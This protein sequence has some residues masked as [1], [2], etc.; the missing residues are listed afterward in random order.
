MK[1][2]K[3]KFKQIIQEECQKLLLEDEAYEKAKKE[4]AAARVARGE[5][6]RAR[7]EREKKA[8]ETRPLEIF[9]DSS[10]HAGRRKFGG[11][12]AVFTWRGTGGEKIAGWYSYLFNKKWTYNPF[13]KT[14]DL[15]LSAISGK[16]WETNENFILP[17]RTKDFSAEGEKE[18]AHM[19]AGMDSSLPSVIFLTGAQAKKYANSGLI[20]SYTK[21]QN[22]QMRN[23][24]KT[25]LLPKIKKTYGK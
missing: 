11:E 9:K 7:Y 24:I 25:K 22:W 18:I 2:K 13:T 10:G 4:R 20:T 17:Y 15:H 23:Y 3:S 16:D 14:R 6:I 5:R 1:I 19:R 12:N 21:G 8:H